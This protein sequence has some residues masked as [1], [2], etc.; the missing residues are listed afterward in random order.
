VESPA[1]VIAFEQVHRRFGEV[2]AVDGL[3][4]AIAEGE[5]FT[6][7]GPS[8]CGKTTSLRLI[9]GF[10]QPDQGDVRLR[11]R[12]VAGVP[13]YRRPV[14][15]VFQHYALFPHLSVGENIAYGLRQR[16]PRPSSAE[17]ARAVDAA[18]AMVRLPGYA[19][20]R[21]HALSGGQQQRVALARALVN[22]PA[23]L[24]LDE[25]LAALDRKLR[26]E[27][28]IELQNLQREVGITFVL[29]TH[30]QEEALSMSDRVCIM[31]QGRIV[32]TGAPRDL[33]DEPIDAY[34]ADF[35][36]KSNLLPAEVL[37]EGG[38]V[39]RV[40]GRTVRARRPKG[41]RPLPAGTAAVLAIRPE[42]MRLGSADGD[43]IAGRVHNRIFLG[44]HTELVVSTAALGDLL[45]LVPRGAEAGAL[46]G[47]G[48]AVTVTWPETAALALS[49]G[50]EPEPGPPTNERNAA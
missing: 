18:L 2:R 3:S 13:A 14:N 26:R 22:R 25:P 9:A 19:Q 49:D 39:L 33:Y 40:A 11:G 27:M 16:R 42:R 48:D 37:G 10:E 35:V 45:V 30:D 34:V 32:Q 8:G 38:G 12:S 5:F 17:I 23:V 6:F 28:Q 24:L 21:I 20:R 47:P 7:L 31:R 4:L 50:R 46:P 36:G 43:G 44:E 41:A 1:P 15:M 29:V